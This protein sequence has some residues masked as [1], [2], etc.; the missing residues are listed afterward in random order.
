MQVTRQCLALESV[1][2]WSEGDVSAGPACREW[3]NCSACHIPPHPSALGTSMAGQLQRLGLVRVKSQVRACS[4]QLTSC[5][6]TSWKQGSHG[7]GR[8]CLQDQASCSDRMD[9]SMQGEAQIAAEGF[10]QSGITS[11]SRMYKPC[12][13]STPPAPG[14]TV[15]CWSCGRNLWSLAGV[16]CQVKESWSLFKPYLLPPSKVGFAR[17]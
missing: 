6:G 14:Y 2:K 10:V 1:R 11:Y 17:G 16:P 3:R 8:H 9:A 7:Y 15:L 5:A 12:L 13:L 4:L